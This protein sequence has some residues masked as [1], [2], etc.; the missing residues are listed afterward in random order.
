ML[1]WFDDGPGT[2]KASTTLRPATTILPTL[3]ASNLFVL[4]LLGQVNCEY[5]SPIGF[6]DHTLEDGQVTLAAG[7]ITVDEDNIKKYLERE[8]SCEARIDD[9]GNIEVYYQGKNAAKNENT[10]KNGCA[11]DLL[12]KHSNMIKFKAV[13]RDKGPIVQCATDCDPARTFVDGI[14]DNLIPFAYSYNTTKESIAIFKGGQKEEDDAEICRRPEDMECKHGD[15]YRCMRWAPLTVGWND[16]EIRGKSGVYA[17]TALF[18][19]DSWHVLQ[20]GRD[21]MSFNLTITGAG[22]LMMSSNGK[23]TE[24]G[25]YDPNERR[26]FMFGSEKIE[27]FHC[28]AEGEGVARPATWKI[29]GTNPASD[30][31]YNRLLTFYLL[32][33]VSARIEKY[34]ETKGP[35]CE[36]LFIEF[37]KEYYILLAADPPTTP[38]KPKTPPVTVTKPTVKSTQKATTTEPPSNN[39]VW[40]YVVGGVLFVVALIVAASICFIVNKKKVDPLKGG[41]LTVAKTKVDEK[42]KMKEKTKVDEKTKM[43]E[44]LKAGQ[45]K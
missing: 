8:G 28:L 1:F 5:N 45:R 19:I 23:T 16:C 11:V 14:I 37:D 38:A 36:Q 6:Y 15:K 43:K 33:Q 26:N 13:V 39:M 7:S 22:G 21:L 10:K 25:T 34:G 42:T 35:K 3:F 40:V 41:D 31:A 30:P 27:R 12:T 32:P 4:V 18:G 20:K 24:E 17:H 9:D 44:K 2:R 29:D